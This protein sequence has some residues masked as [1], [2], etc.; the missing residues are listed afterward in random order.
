MLHLA[1]H[2]NTHLA[3]GPH[4]AIL[5]LFGA[6]I[7]ATVASYLGVLQFGAHSVSIFQCVEIPYMA[8][9]FCILAAMAGYYL[10]WKYIVGFVNRVLG[11]A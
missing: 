4:G 8:L 2:E 6:P 3:I 11:I 7:G 9:P 5:P 1:S 10:V